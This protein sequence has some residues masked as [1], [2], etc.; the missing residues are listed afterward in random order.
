MVELLSPAGNLE[1]LIYA[2]EYGADAVYIGG[3][4]FGLRAAS[5]NFD[6]KDI[7]KALEI[8]EKAGKKLY[9]AVNIF[10]YQED[11]AGIKE[12][13]R[14]LADIRP[15]ALIVS[16]PGIFNLAKKI[17][18]EIDLHIST[19]ANVTNLEGALF[20]QEQGAKRI[21]LAR[22]LSLSQIKEISEGLEIGVEVFAHGAMC[23]SYSG[24][25]WL[26]HYLTERDANRGD[27]SQS[28][29]WN[30]ALVEEKRPDEAMAI[31]E[32][33]AGTYILSSKDLCLAE[34]VD[35]LIKAGVSSLKIE[36]RMKSIHYVATVTK[37]Y[38]EII[39]K[40]LKEKDDF[41]FDKNWLDE[42]NKISHRQYTKGFID[43]PGNDLQVKGPVSY[44]KTADFVGLVAEKNGKGCKVKIKNRIEVGDE[45]EVLTPA[46]DNK[47]AKAQFC[48][49]E[50][51]A[52]TEVHANSNAWFDNDWP[53]RSLIRKKLKDA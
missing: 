44:F 24:R 1:K 10:A 8:V 43:G 53:V 27:C 35:E 22:E 16:D 34:K 52:L 13:L 28:C 7:E 9:V 32:D 3:S 6:L 23:L 4:S 29:R 18:P 20:W 11:L 50:G 21:T 39:N 36:G 41:V 49:E 26:S 30:Y 45:L 42:L 46:G 33:G 17:C 40:A 15:A 25:C 14:S 31:F 2:L 12:F 19:Q 5:S 47:Q 37:T 38:R 48:D 51:T